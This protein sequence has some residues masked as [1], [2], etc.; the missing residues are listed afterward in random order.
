[1]CCSGSLAN[2]SVSQIS[3]QREQYLTRSPSSVVV[4]FLRMVQLP[5][6]CPRAAGT[7]SVAVAPHREQVLTVVPAEVQVA[8]TVT[9]E[10]KLWLQVVL[11]PVIVPSV[12]PLVVPFVVP[13]AV[14]TV[15]FVDLVSTFP[16]SLQVR[17]L[18]PLLV[19]VAA[20]VTSHF[21]QSCS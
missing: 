4:A 6:R 20:V 17:V 12:D 7:A 16:Q 13:V 15:A 11:P 19:V 2:I 9:L 8:F 3:P 1:M 18:T 10:V 14:T 21:P 5:A